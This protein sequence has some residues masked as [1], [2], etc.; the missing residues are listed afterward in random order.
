MPLASFARL[1]ILQLVANDC[2]GVLRSIV[3]RRVHDD[4]RIRQV[5][6]LRAREGG[7]HLRAVAVSPAPTFLLD[8]IIVVRIEVQNPLDRFA[9]IGWIGSLSSDVLVSTNDR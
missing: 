4:N 1:V 3:L 8:P 5:R 2:L 6:I 9:V 7:F